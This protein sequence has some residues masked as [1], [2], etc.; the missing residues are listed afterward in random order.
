MVSPQFEAG[1]LPELRLL[2]RH[3]LYGGMHSEVFPNLG[4][5]E[6]LTMREQK[7]RYEAQ[8]KEAV[9]EMGQVRFAEGPLSGALK[10]KA[11]GILSV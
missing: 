7:S 5:L 1:G 10:F 9:P 3:L 11:P 6:G 2:A 4:D 8:H